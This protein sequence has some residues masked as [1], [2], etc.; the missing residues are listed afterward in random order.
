[1]IYSRNNCFSTNWFSDTVMSARAAKITV[2]FTDSSEGRLNSR[3][4][5][6]CI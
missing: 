3:E 2:Y 1:M 5:Y 4:T 6:T